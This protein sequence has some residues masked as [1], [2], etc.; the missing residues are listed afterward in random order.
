M[1]NDPSGMTCGHAA[2][3]P[4]AYGGKTP[5]AITG[6]NPNALILRRETRLCPADTLCYQHWL[7]YQERWT[8]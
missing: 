6:G 5:G 3:T 1:T 8:H 7:P 4:V 2:L